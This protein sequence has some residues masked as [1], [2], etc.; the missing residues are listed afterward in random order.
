M[1][2][3]MS[4]I[5]IVVL[6]VLLIAPGAMAQGATPAEVVQ[7]YY[8]ALSQAAAGGDTAGLLDLFADDATVE[9]TGLTPQPVSGKEA[10]QTTLGGMFALL[11][12]LTVTMGDVAVEGDQVVVNY[13]MATASS[14]TAIP[15]TDTFVVQEGKIQSLTIAL[16]PEA[17]AGATAA[18]AAT[19]TA[20]PATGGPV[21]GLLPSLLAL[22]G[23]ALMAFSRRFSR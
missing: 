12:G 7:G 20:L 15:A 3:R 5:L 22:S 1:H 2:R 11:Q 16:A 6:A 21:S 13:T 8:A 17:L 4:G 19:P 10:I 14:P 23:A 18:A 9:V